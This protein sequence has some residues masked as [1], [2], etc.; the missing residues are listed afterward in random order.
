MKQPTGKWQ[1]GRWDSDERQSVEGCAAP[2]MCA[3]AWCRWHTAQGRWLGVAGAGTL[4]AVPGT[5]AAGGGS[6][7]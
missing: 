7:P 2:A 3:A 5:K 4:T 1:P 6:A